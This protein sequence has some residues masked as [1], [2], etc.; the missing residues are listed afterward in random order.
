MDK[1]HHPQVFRSWKVERLKQ[2]QQQAKKVL[3]KGAQ[4]ERKKNY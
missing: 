3:R 4:P 1:P 2:R